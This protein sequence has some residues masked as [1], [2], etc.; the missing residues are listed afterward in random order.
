MCI[1]CHSEQSEESDVIRQILRFAQNDKKIKYTNNFNQ[2]LIRTKSM[3]LKF[4]QKKPLK[5]FN[6]RGFYLIGL[7]KSN[8]DFHIN[9]TWQFKFHQRIY[10][11]WTCRINVNKTFVST[12]LELFTCFFINVR[13]T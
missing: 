8:F 7:Q 9:T 13:R 1:F 3:I 4:P 11:F 12:Q 10:S 5:L 2:L 6:L